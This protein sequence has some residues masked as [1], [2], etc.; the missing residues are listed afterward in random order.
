MYKHRY[1]KYAVYK[2]TNIPTKSIHVYIID[3]HADTPIKL[4]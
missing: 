1:T 2:L 4:K 3:I